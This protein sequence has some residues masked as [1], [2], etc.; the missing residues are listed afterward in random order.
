MGMDQ[1]EGK[2]GKRRGQRSGRK[3][4]R[5]KRKMEKM[6][7]QQQ[8]TSSDCGR[9][10]SRSVKTKD[11]VDCDATPRQRLKIPGCIKHFKMGFEE[12]WPHKTSSFKAKTSQAREQV[13]YNEIA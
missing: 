3:R 9:S 2:G 1:W 12:S 8:S 13:S 10:L 7:Q 5:K 6:K 4:R 11:Y